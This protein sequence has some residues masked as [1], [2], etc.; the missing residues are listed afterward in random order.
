MATTKK[1][2]SSVCPCSLQHNLRI[3][4]CPHFNWQVICSF[5]N[6]IGCFILNSLVQSKATC[7]RPENSVGQEEVCCLLAWTV[8]KEGTW[9]AAY[10]CVWHGRVWH[11]QYSKSPHAGILMLFILEGY[12]NVLCPH[13]LKYSTF[14]SQKKLF[15]A[16]SP[17]SCWRSHIGAV[18]LQA[19]DGL[20][21]FSTPV[22]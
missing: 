21:W 14:V 17:I 2:T 11:R 9:N 6:T 7:Q 3:F 15:P 8:C 20:Q 16:V 5:N 12:K 22:D 4:V 19:T 1:A 13:C 10:C 18:V